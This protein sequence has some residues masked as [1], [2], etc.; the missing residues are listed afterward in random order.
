MLGVAFTVIF[1]TADEEVQPAVLVPVTEYEVEVVGLTTMVEP[2]YV[3]GLQ[4]Y[5]R[6]SGSQCS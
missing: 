2:I 4:V 5:A 3:P 6:S 1:A